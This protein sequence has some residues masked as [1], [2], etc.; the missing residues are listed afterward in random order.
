MSMELIN[1]AVAF[2]GI[3]AQLLGLLGFAVLVILMVFLVD[4]VDLLYRSLPYMKLAPAYPRS[5]F[6]GR[7]WAG[8]TT[9]EGLEKTWL[10][11]YYRVSFQL[12]NCIHKEKL[13]A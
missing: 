13:V 8:N 3:N 4:Y 12:L 6:M 10:D 9:G 2:V 11:G 5:Y 7:F 1:E